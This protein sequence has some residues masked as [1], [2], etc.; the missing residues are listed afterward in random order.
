[1]ACAAVSGRYSGTDSSKVHSR[2]YT[3]RQEHCL[4]PPLVK[5]RAEGMV[6][7][8]LVPG[9]LQNEPTYQGTT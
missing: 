7:L 3:A 2:F 9:S 5:H 4:R 8:H 6:V 1:M